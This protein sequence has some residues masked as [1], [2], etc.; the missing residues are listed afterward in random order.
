MGKDKRGFVERSTNEAPIA[1][2]LHKR[3]HRRRV[4]RSGYIKG[5]ERQDVCVFT[6]PKT[7]GSDRCLHTSAIARASE[8]KVKKEPSN[9]TL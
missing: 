8:N 4:V 1:S 9:I 2:K 5:K 3:P 7:F 6:L